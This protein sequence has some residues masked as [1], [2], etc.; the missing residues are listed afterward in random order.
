[1]HGEIQHLCQLVTREQ[2]TEIAILWFR[3]Y[4]IEQSLYFNYF[5]LLR[6]SYV[7]AVIATWLIANISVE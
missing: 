4:R 3:R 1:M 7:F 2:S 5:K 6:V